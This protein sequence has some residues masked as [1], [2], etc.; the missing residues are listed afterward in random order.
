M[1]LKPCH[2]YL[3]DYHIDGNSYHQDQYLVPC[4]SDYQEFQKELFLDPLSLETGKD[5]LNPDDVKW[6]L[7][8]NKLP[9]SESNLVAQY[10]DEK[11][12]VIFTEPVDD[13]GQFKF[14]KLPEG[15]PYIMELKAKD[16]SLCDKLEV[17]LVDKDNNQIGTTERDGRC[18]YTY[19]KNS[20]V[21]IE[22]PNKNNHVPINNNNSNVKVEPAFY[23]KHYAYNI[24]DVAKS[25]QEFNDFVE[26]AKAIIDTRGYVILF[27]EG[28]ASK[29]PTTT[30]KTND[31]LSR[32]RTNDAKNRFLEVLQ[33]KGGD[34]GKVRFK[35]INSLVQGPAYKNDFMEN[36]AVYEKYQY[37]KLSA[38]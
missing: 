37:I 13:K 10:L 35:S 36:K 17:V 21:V 11:N 22:D 38:K 25:E 29:V 7:L 14:H 27:I 33:A 2:E 15:K 5:S 1:S 26:K 9:H 4:E 23:E 31:K 8:L 12:G 3:I 6:K 34:P 19:K 28:S 20:D 32:S 18:K 30:F 16:V 24:K